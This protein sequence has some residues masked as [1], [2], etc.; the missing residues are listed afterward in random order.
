MALELKGQLH[1]TQK[2]TFV[3]NCNISHSLYLVRARGVQEGWKWVRG[4]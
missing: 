1:I 2:R 4:E 3:Q